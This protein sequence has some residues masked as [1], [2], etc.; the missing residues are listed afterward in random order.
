M[1][2]ITKNK[3]RAFTSIEMAVGVSI[4]GV[5]LVYTMYSIMQFVNSARD[6]TQKTEAIYLAEDG[7]ELVRFMRDEDWTTLSGFTLNTPLYVAVSAAAI[8]PTTTP[9]IVDGFTRSFT[10]QNLYRNSST[11]DIVASTTGGSIIDPN[12]RYVTM[13]V[14][15]GTAGEY[16]ALS[17]IL[18]NIHN[19]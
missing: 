1:F 14:G 4:A 7:L 9:E 17:T 18:T 8:V 5:I 16:V 15:W 2:G 10:M 3:I 6:I 19:P 12:G 13:T 11:D